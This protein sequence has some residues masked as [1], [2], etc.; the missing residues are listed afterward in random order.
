MVQDEITNEPFRVDHLLKSELEKKILK[1]ESGVVEHIKDILQKL[2]SNQLKIAEIESVIQ[3]FQIKSPKTGNKLTK[4]VP[5][6]LMFQTTVGPFAQY[7]RY[8]DD[9]CII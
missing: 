7:K 1:N 8:F 2:D 9:H 6:N 4:P 5:F 3:K